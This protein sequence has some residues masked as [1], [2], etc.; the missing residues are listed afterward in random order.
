M[1]GG[2]IIGQMTGDGRANGAAGKV[3]ELRGRVSCVCL[4]LNARREHGG[5][6]II[7]RLEILFAVLA[8]AK[9]TFTGT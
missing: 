3:N 2:R 5:Y 1:Y 8:L 9:I 4:W 7:N 6:V